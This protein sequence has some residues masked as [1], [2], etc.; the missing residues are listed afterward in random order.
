MDA[1]PG[2]HIALATIIKVAMGAA[3]LF[4]AALPA[5]VH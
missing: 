3:V 2:S 4:I 5:I 1:R